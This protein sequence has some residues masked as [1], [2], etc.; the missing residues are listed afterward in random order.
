MSIIMEG[1][2]VNVNVRIKQVVRQQF[3]RTSS[4][5]ASIFRGLGSYFKTGPSF[6]G[7]TW[8]VVGNMQ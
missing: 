7:P 3:S 1:E 8:L 2:I 4:V 5:I 6:A